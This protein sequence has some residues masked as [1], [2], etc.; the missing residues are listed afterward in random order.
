MQ[1]WDWEQ[2][3]WPLLTDHKVIGLEGFFNKHTFAARKNIL[4][5]NMLPQQQQIKKSWHNI[6]MDDIPTKYFTSLPPKQMFY[7]AYI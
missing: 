5:L 6:L 2:C 3:S 1:S 7:Y 4:L